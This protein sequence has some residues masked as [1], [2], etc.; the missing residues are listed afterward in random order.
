MNRRFFGS[1]VI[2]AL[3]SLLGIKTAK[4]AVG[5]EPYAW[6]VEW[7]WYTD[8]AKTS[9]CGRQHMFADE[10]PLLSS[11]RRGCTPEEWAKDF[12]ASLKNSPSIEKA[13][14]FPV[15]K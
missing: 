11:S 9:S 2:G 5:K 8:I 3:A 1:A 7:W 10:R 13:I 12:A 15:Y 4:A 6:V 14:A